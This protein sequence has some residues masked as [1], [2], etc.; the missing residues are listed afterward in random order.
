MIIMI[1]TTRHDKE[2]F[3]VKIRNSWIVSVVTIYSFNA[4]LWQSAAHGDLRRCDEWYFYSFKSNTYVIKSNTYVIESN[5]YVIK[6]NT[7]VIKSYM[8][9]ENGVVTTIGFNKS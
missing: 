4:N 6:S 5:T 7:Y 9:K 8:M 2:L 3:P 1:I